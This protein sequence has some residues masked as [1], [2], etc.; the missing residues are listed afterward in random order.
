MQVV[1]DSSRERSCVRIAVGMLH[2]ETNT[3]SPVKTRKEDFELLRGDELL[4]RIAVTPLF[5][6]AG[7]DIV[8]TLYANALPSGAVEKKTFE[9]PAASRG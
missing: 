3:F 7:V 4:D 2:T 1:V 5:R 9:D 8:P 6:T